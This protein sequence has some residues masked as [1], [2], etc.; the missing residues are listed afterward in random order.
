MI[1]ALPTPPTRSDPSTFAARGDAFLT[2]LTTFVT[3]ANDLAVAMNLNSLVLA[4]GIS[5]FL[6]TPSSANLLAAMT[7]KTGTGS[8]VFSDSPTLVTPNLGTPSTLIGTN[9]TGTADSLTAGQATA[10]LGLKTATTTVSISAS[11][12]PTSGQV[13]VA[14]STT[15]AAW[16]STASGLTAGLAT[17]ANGIKT[18]TT[19]V[20]VSASTAPTSG[21]VLVASSTTLAA[22][23]NQSVTLNNVTASAG[24]A[25]IANADN[26]MAWNW[27]ITTAGKTGFAIGET[28]ASTNGV[29]SQYLLSVA[30]IASSTANPFR[31]Q[32]RGATDSILVGRTGDVS[33][34]GN[35]VTSG[36][37][38]AITI[39][40]G[41]GTF[42]GGIGGG[43]YITAGNSAGAGN[44][45]DITLTTGTAAS[46]SNGKI[47]FVNTNVANG[48]VATAMSSVGPTG[49]N[50]AIQGWLAI[51]VGGT[52]RY[53]PFW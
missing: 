32:T 13:L 51:K 49:A 4:S 23:A 9:I 21:Q 35:N 37:A 47:N 7:T 45:G 31:V 40:A 36:T 22:W 3:E 30:T 1:T 39:T 2:A 17:A 11:T 20:A 24:A 41:S 44:G 18:A 8:V 34:T 16:S 33:V 26:A 29:G 15:L 50:T 53:I 48:A 42:G 14:S 5:T 10:G 25:T 28:S 27:T 12:A 43:V 6:T 19:T 46:G 52:A 38:G